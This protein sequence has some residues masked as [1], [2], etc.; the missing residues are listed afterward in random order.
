MARQSGVLTLHS[1]ATATGNGATINMSLFTMAILQ[2]IGSFNAVVTFEGT[3]DGTN[4]IGIA[5]QDVSDTA[6]VHKTTTNAPGAF[7]V[8]DM[9]GMVLIRARISTYTSGS[10]TVVAQASE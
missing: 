1:A 5:L 6:R 10:I 4:W 8:D 3:I 7:V 2:V 9:R